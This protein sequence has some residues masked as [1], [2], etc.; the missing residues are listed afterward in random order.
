M[1]TLPLVVLP[2]LAL[3]IPVA[4][5]AEPVP[6]DSIIRI[7]DAIVVG[8]LT[9]VDLESTEVVEKGTGYVT[10]EE[11]VV[12]PVEAGDAFPFEWH[13]RFDDGIVCPPPYRHEPLGG[14][15]GVWFLERGPDG[16]LRPNGEIWNLEIPGSLEAYAEMLASLTPRTERTALLLSLVER[17]MR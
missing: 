8:R 7:S 14:A 17:E 9:I 16:V 4:G 1:R 11:V 6:V 2:A 12:G 13:V 15:L 5:L 3:A 10:V